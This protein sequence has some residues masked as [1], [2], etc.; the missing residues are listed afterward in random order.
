M[1]SV[2]FRHK[3]VTVYPEDEKKPA[4]GFGLNRKAEITL[5]RVWPNDKTTHVPIKVKKQRRFL[6]RLRNLI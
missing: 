6:L 3:E 4:V 1:F 5:E 2:H